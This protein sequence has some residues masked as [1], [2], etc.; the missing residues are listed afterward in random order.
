ML[1]VV[2]EQVDLKKKHNEGRMPLEVAE[3]ISW[4]LTAVKNSLDIK[5]LFSI[6][7]IETEAQIEWLYDI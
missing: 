2:Q 4:T 7:L 6:A 3:N 1:V 5:H